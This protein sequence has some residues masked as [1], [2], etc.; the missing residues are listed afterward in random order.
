MARILFPLLFGLAVVLTGST[1][2]QAHCEVPCGIYA[3]QMRFEMMLEDQATI[4]KAMEK[5]ASYASTE[6]HHAQELNQQVRWVATKEDHANKIQHVIA[7][8][9]MTQR[10]KP[11][12]DDAAQAVYV[13]QL[14]KAHAVMVLA[15]KCKQTVDPANAVALRQAILDFHKAYEKK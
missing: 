5:I 14:T 2:V 15:M 4:A 6:K 9:F 10:L 7:Q 11:G 13:D 12:A 3:D 8:Y 1:R